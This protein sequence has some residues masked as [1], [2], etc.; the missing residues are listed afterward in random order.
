[1]KNTDDDYL[2]QRTKKIERKK[3]IIIYISFLVFGGY[4]LVSGFQTVFQA[5]ELSERPTVSSTR[6]NSYKF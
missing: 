3:Q 6:K 4:L 5:W 1:M 2:L